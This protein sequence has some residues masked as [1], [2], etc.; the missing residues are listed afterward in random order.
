MRKIIELQKNQIVVQDENTIEFYSY[1]TLIAK[2]EKAE[3]YLTS[4]WN[5]SKTTTRYL[6]EFM[7]KFVW[8]DT[9]SKEI[10]KDLE[11]WLIKLLEIMLENWLAIRQWNELPCEILVR[12]WDWKEQRQEIHT[13]NLYLTN[14]NVCFD[15]FHWRWIDELEKRIVE[16]EK[17]PFIY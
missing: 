5:Y 2:L 14:W 1:W 10:R 9:N 4:Y 13:W 7:R 12:I 3:L 11:K 8:V 6:L 15:I 17:K 16:C